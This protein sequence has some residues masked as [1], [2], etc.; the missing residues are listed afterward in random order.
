LTAHATD[1]PRPSRPALVELA[2][3]ILIVGGIVGLIQVASAS[4]DVPAGAEPFLAGAVA[5]D[6]GSVALGLLVRTG[7]AWLLAVNYAAVLGF[8]DLLG[9][10]ASPFSLMLGLADLLVVA[11]LLGTKPWF[12]A[13][14]AW[15]TETAAHRVSP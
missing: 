11:I 3:A 4:D 7:R 1:P 8:L 9:A 5:L 13:M 14:S 12:D 2:A 6:A 15:R 10:G